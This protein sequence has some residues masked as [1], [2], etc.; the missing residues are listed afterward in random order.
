MTYITPHTSKSILISIIAIVMAT[1]LTGCQKDVERR[2]N[3]PQSQAECPTGTDFRSGGGA[4][5]DRSGG[6]GVID[7]DGNDVINYCEPQC[8]PG[9]SH[10]GDPDMIWH[11]TNKVITAERPCQ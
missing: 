7:R 4:V 2:Y 1:S 6:G 5:I 3:I 8:A 11:D 9:E 10:V